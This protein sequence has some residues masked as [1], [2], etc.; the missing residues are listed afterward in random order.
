VARQLHY[1]LQK[2][3]IIQN[4]NGNIMNLFP[5]IYTSLLIFSIFIVFTILVSYILYKVKNNNSG[6]Q[7]ADSSFVLRRP[8]TP[9]TATSKIIYQRSTS[10][11]HSIRNRYN[12]ESFRRPAEPSFRQYSERQIDSGEQENFNTN[13]PIYKSDS[14]YTILPNFGQESY[15]GGYSNNNSQRG[16]SSLNYYNENSGSYTYRSGNQSRF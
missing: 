16:L 10:S 9:A 11:N 4:N 3:F 6:V 13:S 14:R 5:I 7:N 2:I 8:V 1:S 12:D 15:G